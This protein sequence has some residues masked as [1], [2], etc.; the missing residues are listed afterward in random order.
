M[1]T[2]YFSPSAQTSPTQCYFEGRNM[3]G[4]R[5]EKK[6]KMRKKRKKDKKEGTDVKRVK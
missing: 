4:K 3:N 5:E 1:F 2:C 6:R